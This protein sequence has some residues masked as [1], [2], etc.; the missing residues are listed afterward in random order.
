M[1]AGLIADVL[2][3]AVAIAIKLGG[4]MLILSMAA[5][6]IIAIFQAVTQI[7]E[8]TIG[9][10]LKVSIIVTVLL[11]SGGWMLSTLQDYARELFDLMKTI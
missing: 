3:D 9:F 7:H 1:D 5:G 10:I 2:R 11:I 8:Q 6:V 4:P